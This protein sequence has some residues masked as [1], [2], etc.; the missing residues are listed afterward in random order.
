MKDITPF[1]VIGWLREQGRMYN[2]MADRI[3]RNSKIT[4]EPSHGDGDQ[5]TLPN[6]GTI[7]PEKVR[8][9]VS[10]KAMRIATLATRFSVPEYEVEAILDS[11]DSGLVRGKQGW[12]TMKDSK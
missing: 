2:Q 11:P 12:I 1:D 7:T 8:E 6:L 5:K 10:K 3:E 4:P 9:V